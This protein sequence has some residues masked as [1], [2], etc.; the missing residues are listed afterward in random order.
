MKRLNGKR[1]LL[2]AAAWDRSLLVVAGLQVASGKGFVARAVTGSQW[3]AK[4][5]DRTVIRPHHLTSIRPDRTPPTPTSDVNLLGDFARVRQGRRLAV[6][7]LV[8]IIQMQGADITTPD[9]A[10]YGAVTY[11]TAGNYEFAGSQ[12]LRE[13]P[14]R[15]VVIGRKPIRGR[16]CPGHSCP[17]V[18]HADCH[19]A[20]SITAPAWNGTVVAWLRCK[21]RTTL[22]L[23]RSID[24]TG[25]G[26]AGGAVDP[27]SEC[28]RDVNRHLPLRRQYGRRR[29]GREHRRASRQPGQWSLWPGRA[30]QRRGGGEFAQFGRRWRSPML[31]LRNLDGRGPD[32]RGNRRNCRGHQRLAPRPRLHRQR[33]RAHYF[34]GGG[35]GGYTYSASQHDPTGHG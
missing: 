4:L 27:A 29:E 8:L 19:G 5:A 35:R 2:R 31:P 15:W 9:S 25:T 16:Q 34:F 22:Q 13:T 20:G 7:D 11:N 30:C 6:G 26:F 23:K 12:P 24:V 1:G 14:S 17:T 3:W 10:I 21:R 33:R 28:Y 32:E 18:R